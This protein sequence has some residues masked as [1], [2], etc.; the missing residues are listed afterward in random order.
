MSLPSKIFPFTVNN[1][2]A[3]SFST[4]KFTY[5]SACTRTAQILVTRRKFSEAVLTS[6]QL[7]TLD[8]SAARVESANFPTDKK[9]S[10]MGFIWRLWELSSNVESVERVRLFTKK[11][12]LQEHGKTTNH[13]KKRLFCQK[14]AL[15][16]KQAFS[17]YLLKFSVVYDENQV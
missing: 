9:L 17:S 1:W 14:D 7:T 6:K 3:H 16:R 13:D 15:V 5:W 8:F 11:F 10:T 2:F 4:T 12:T